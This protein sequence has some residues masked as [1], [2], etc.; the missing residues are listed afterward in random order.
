MMV[1][2]KMMMTIITD[3]GHEPG[4][5]WNTEGILSTWKT[6]GILRDICVT[7]GKNYNG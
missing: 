3:G 2:M 6:R 1:L 7:L 4:E 5:T